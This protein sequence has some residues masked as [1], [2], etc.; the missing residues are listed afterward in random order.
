MTM[1]AGETPATLLIQ[2][3]SADL[4]DE[5]VD[6]LTRQ[7]ATEL[8]R[9]ADVEAVDLVGAAPIEG[10]KSGDA[11]DIGTLAAQVL[12]AALP[13]LL[14]ALREWARRPQ[15]PPVKVK[16]KFGEITFPRDR[17]THEQ[18]LELIAAMKRSD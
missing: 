18:L 15:A 8:R 4:D 11:V 3:D 12:P 14:S 2:I 16:G 13:L 10:G 6:R 7:L 1:A 5:T 9:A 17:M